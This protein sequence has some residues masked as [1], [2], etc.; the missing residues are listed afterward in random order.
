[1][2]RRILFVGGVHG[3]GKSTLCNSICA[4]INAEHHSASELI[5]KFGQVNHSI[6]K[7]VVDIDKNQDV[8]IAAVNEYL[9]G[10]RPYLL[11]G[12]CC[13]LNQNGDVIEIP[14][15]TF[16]ALS[17]V[18]MLVLVDDPTKIFARLKDRDKGRYDV[19][20]LSSF[21]E[22]ELNYSESVASKLGVPYLKANP[23][24]DDE[25]IIRFVKRF[26]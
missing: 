9:V 20:L 5:S 3:V 1:M 10:V 11:D 2:K 7:R 16:Q 26:L 19:G 22:K 21:Q 18:A 25:E 13:L 6:N 12:H 4:Q 24:M 14:F 17:P 8:L 23:F 15:S